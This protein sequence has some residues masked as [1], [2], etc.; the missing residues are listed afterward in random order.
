MHGAIFLHIAPVRN[1]DTSPVATQGAAGTYIYILADH[2]I[3]RH[4][5]LGMNKGAFMRHRFYTI[6]FVKHQI[7]FF[8]VRKQVPLNNATCSSRWFTTVIRYTPVLLPLCTSFA[9][10]VSTSPGMAAFVNVM[11]TSSATDKLFRLLH[12]NANALSASEKV[13]PP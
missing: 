10:A 3:A 12:A 8:P 2:H 7:R 13:M 4:G 9:S 5:C 1:N 11:V 6:E